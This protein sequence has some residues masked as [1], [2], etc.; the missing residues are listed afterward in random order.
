[1][2][3]AAED[4]EAE[5]RANAMFERGGGATEVAPGDRAFA[6]PAALPPAAAATAVVVPKFEVT[7]GG[8]VYAVNK[9]EGSKALRA[10]MSA[11]ESAQY[12]TTLTAYKAYME[13]DSDSD[14]D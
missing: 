11:A 9:L 7:V 1:M 13:D 14:S 5:A 2:E 3:A 10:A 8:I 6:A 12:E 4:A